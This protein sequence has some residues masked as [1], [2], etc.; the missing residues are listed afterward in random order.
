M[1][2]TLKAVSRCYL[3]SLISSASVCVTMV[4]LGG[5]AGVVVTSQ[6]YR[7]SDGSFEGPVGKT[8]HSPWSDWF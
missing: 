4:V 2:H 5:A 8:N 6:T 3:T 7:K 1:R